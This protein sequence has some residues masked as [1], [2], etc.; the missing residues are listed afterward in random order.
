MDCFQD[1]CLSCDRASTTGAYCSQAC[2][3]ADME[4]ATGSPP[5]SPIS[6]RHSARLSWSSTSSLQHAHSSPSRPA[7]QLPSHAHRPRTSYFTTSVAQHQDQQQH[8]VLSPSSS[9]T[10]LAS[11]SSDSSVASGRISH[12]AQM[13]LQDYFKSFNAAQASK[14]RPSK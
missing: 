13:E 4:R 12:Q 14:R 7:P 9:R 10:S 8:F 2:R 1:F 6:Q 3:L 5:A 11:A